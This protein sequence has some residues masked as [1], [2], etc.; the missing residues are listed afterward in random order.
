[1]KQQNSFSILWLIYINP[2][3]LDPMANFSEGKG[4]SG[5]RVDLIIIT[6]NEKTK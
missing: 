4:G 2:S 6:L 1:M 5:A 3:L